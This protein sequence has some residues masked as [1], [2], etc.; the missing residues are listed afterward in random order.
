MAKKTSV[1]SSQPPMPGKE[2]VQKEFTETGGDTGNPAI[3]K[4]GSKK[5]AR[6]ASEKM[7]Q[8]PNRKSTKPSE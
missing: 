8:S 1:K 6:P 3:R 7:N 2:R 5:P 4:H